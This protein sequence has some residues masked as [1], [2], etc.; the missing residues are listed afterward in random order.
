[1]LTFV[2]FNARQLAATYGFNRKI[3]K[4][5]ES[6]GIKEVLYTE[7]INIEDFSLDVLLIDEKMYFHKIHLNSNLATKMLNEEFS[8]VLDSL[9][10]SNIM[11]H[12]DVSAFSKDCNL[13]EEINSILSRAMELLNVENSSNIDR[14]ENSSSS[15]FGVNLEHFSYKD[16]HDAVKPLVKDF[17]LHL[18]SFKIITLTKTSIEVLAITSEC[19][20]FQYTIQVSSIYSNFINRYISAILPYEYFIE[21][22]RNLKNLDFSA[23]LKETFPIYKSKKEKLDTCGFLTFLLNTYKKDIKGE[24]S[25]NEGLKNFHKFFFDTCATKDEA[26]SKIRSCYMEAKTYEQKKQLPSNEEGTT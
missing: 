13:I 10:I 9:G 21:M 16:V 24:G 26:M 3:N 12:L 18:H 19:K 11:P 23:A 7:I 5:A 2:N 4:I 22:K 6:L 25:G 15:Q 8:K 20:L 17:I 14:L 1:M